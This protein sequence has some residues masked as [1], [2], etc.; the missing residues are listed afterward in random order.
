MPQLKEED[1][2]AKKKVVKKKVVKKKVVKKASKS[3]IKEQNFILIILKIFMSKIINLQNNSDLFEFI[4]SV[5]DG[6]IFAYPTEAVFGL[7]CDINNKY[8]IQKI[9]YKEKRC[10]KRINSNF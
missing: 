6:A 3:N 2:A 10:L 5:K 7:G 1:L 9:L 8:A 4:E